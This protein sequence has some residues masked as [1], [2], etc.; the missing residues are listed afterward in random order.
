M[1]TWL[2]LKIGPDPPE[3]ASEALLRDLRAVEVTRSN[4]APSG[5]QLTFA[6]SRYDPRYTAEE[7]SPSDVEWPLLSDETLD[8][9]NRVQ[10]LVQLD[11]TAP[12]V[13][14]DGFIT[15]Q[16]LN[17]GGEGG[18]SIV[19]TGEDVSLKMDLF[20]ISAEYQD[21]ATSAVVSQILGKYSALGITADVTAPEGETVPTDYVPQQ[22]STD[23]FYLQMLAAQNGYEFYIQP[24]SSAGENTAYWGPPVANMTPV[25]DPQTA[26]VTQMGKRDNVAALNLSYDALAPTLAYANVLDLTQTP[27]ASE[28]VA[29]GSAT[30]KPD[31]S[32]GGAIPS[33]PGGSG[34]AQDP[35]TFSD[36]L[37]SLAVRGRLANNPGYPLTEATAIA[38]AK[39]NRSVVEVITVEGE[40]ETEDYQAVL[41]APGL[42]DILGIG[43][44]YG[45]TYAVKEVTHS[46]K[47]KEEDFSYRQKFVL[48]RGGLGYKSPPAPQST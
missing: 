18:S 26:L 11:A 34:L 7:E 23:R 1:A 3:D 39:T 10:I 40:I 41:Q 45:G 38:Q 15:R 9:F 4:Q 5:F 21:L 16:E 24:G 44:K 17:V 36:S 48:I 47:L 19:V 28:A 14:I 13:L 6:A 42:V 37:A 8:T 12:V 35:P 20:E 30:Q 32:T 25:P 33:T 31:L 46:F 29:I 43:D 27:A 2:T 22:N